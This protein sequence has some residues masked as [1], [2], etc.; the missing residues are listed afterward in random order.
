MQQPAANH[1]GSQD[2]GERGGIEL[3]KHRVVQ[4]SG[5]VH[6]PANLRPSFSAEPVEKGA[7]LRFVGDVD[8]GKVDGGSTSFERANRCNLMREAATRFD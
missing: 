3:R 4:H 2:G 6:D 8:G 7:H 1:F 5:G